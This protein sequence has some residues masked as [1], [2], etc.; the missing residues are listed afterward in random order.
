M[1][2][3]QDWQSP[4][5]ANLAQRLY[6]SVAFCQRAFFRLYKRRESLHLVS[7]ELVHRSRTKFVGARLK[8]PCEADESTGQEQDDPN[9][10]N[11]PP[12]HQPARVTRAMAF[13]VVVL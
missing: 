1:E 10:Q 3:L 7:G 2:R 11:G 6:R 12:V 8:M 9:S 13:G 4:A 5:V